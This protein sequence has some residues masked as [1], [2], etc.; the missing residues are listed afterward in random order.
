MITRYSYLYIFPSLGRVVVM[1]TAEQ[2]PLSALHMAKL[3]VEA[4][5]PP[6][7]VNIISGFGE[8]AGAAL[9]QHPDVNKVSRKDI[10][11]LL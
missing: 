8:T 6:G 7:V 5:F 3:M 11:A 9:V 2:T 10:V 1:K 4:G